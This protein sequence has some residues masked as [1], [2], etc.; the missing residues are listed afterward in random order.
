MHPFRRNSFPSISTN[1]AYV[2]HVIFFGSPMKFT[3]LG[4]SS[5]SRIRIIACNIGPD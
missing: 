1:L 5:L 2:S 3:P 4:F